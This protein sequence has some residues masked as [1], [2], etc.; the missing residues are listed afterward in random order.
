MHAHTHSVTS[1]KRDLEQSNL[2]CL[3]LA[4]LRGRIANLRLNSM[5]GSERA[6]QA[7]TKLSHLE[8][9][10]TSPM[11]MRAHK[12][13]FTFAESGNSL[14]AAFLGSSRIDFSYWSLDTR[15]DCID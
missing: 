13:S 8:Q 15:S 9:I 10:L 5:P 11:L 6:A 14:S 12:V 2:Q 1:H 4:D 3:A 7:T